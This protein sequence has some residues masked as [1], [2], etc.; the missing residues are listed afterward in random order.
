L[1]WRSICDCRSFGSSF[2]CTWSK[3]VFAS[4]LH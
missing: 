3:L 2:K 4:Q 1:A